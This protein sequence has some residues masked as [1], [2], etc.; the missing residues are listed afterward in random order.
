VSTSTSTETAAE[1]PRE[2]ALR[3]EVDRLSRRNAALEHL[4]ALVVAADTWDEAVYRCRPGDDWI[5]VHRESWG[6][7]RAAVDAV[8][9]WRPWEGRSWRLRTTKEVDPNVRPE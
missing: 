9:A 7:I 3:A 2:R 6:R 1:T 4:V 8:D 5:L